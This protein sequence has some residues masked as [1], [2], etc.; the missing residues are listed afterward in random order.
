[1]NSMFYGCSSL[2]SLDLPNIDDSNIINMNSMFYGCSSLIYLNL[3]NF[4]ISDMN[5]TFYGCSSLTFLNLSNVGISDLYSMNSTFYGCSSLMSLDLPNIDI[6]NVKNMNSMFYGC[7]LLTFLDLHNFNTFLVTNMD[8][9]FYGCSSLTSI[10][11]S[12]F[13]TLNVKSMNSM[14]KFCSSLISLDLSNFNTSNVN[15]MDS[16]FEYCSSLAT[17]NLSSFN[18]TNLKTMNSFFSGCSSLIS[19]DLSSF[20]TSNVIYMHSMFYDCS[21]MTYLI[22]SNFDTSNVKEMYSMFS[23]CSILTSLDLSNFK[24]S[25]LE[26]MNYMFYGCSSLTSLD[27]GNFDTSNVNWMNSMFYGCSSLISLDLR[28]FITSSVKWMYSMFYGCS[29]LISLDLTKFDTS[30]V[31]NINSMFYGCSSLIS[32]DLTNFDTS[33]V[34]NMNFMF[35]GCSSLTYINL[36]NFITSKV[37]SMNSMF[38]GCFSLTTLDLSSFD[39]SLVTDMNQM[40]Y[41]CSSL[42]SLNLSNFNTP[43]INNINNM[44]AFCSNLEYINL[45]NFKDIKLMS[46]QNIFYESSECFVLC[47]NDNFN[48][49]IIFSQIGNKCITFDC[50]TDWKLKS[51]IRVNINGLCY[52]ENN[53]DILYKYEYNG[54]YYENCLYGNLFNNSTISRCNCDYEKCS[55]CPKEA[56]KESLCSNCKTNF[57]PIENDTSNIDKYINCY[58]E[59]IGYYLDIDIY[60]KCYNICDHYIQKEYKENNIT[61]KILSISSNA[62]VVYECKSDDNSNSNCNFQNIENNTEILNI[63]K[64]NIVALYSPDDGKSQVIKGENNT[65]FQIT[66]GKNELELLEGGFL[67]NQNISILDL[68]ECENTLKEHYHIN[69]SDSLIILKKENTLGK[70]SEKNVEYEVFEPYNFKPL[71]LSICKGNTINIYVKAELSENTRS[72]YE[73]M[74]SLGYDMLNINDPFYQDICIPYKNENNTD[75]LLSDRINYIYNNKD[76]QCQSNCQFSS[77]LKNSLYLNCTCEAGSDNVDNKKEEDKFSGKKLYESF[78]DVLKYSNFKIIKCYNLVLSKNVVS[79]NFGSIIIMV[80]FSIYLICLITFIIKGIIPLMNQIKIFK[81]K[82]KDIINNFNKNNIIHGNKKEN[83]ENKNIRGKNIKNKKIFH[84]VKKNIYLDK[85]ISKGKIGSSNR[86]NEGKK[87]IKKPKLLKP[88][89]FNFP[90]SKKNFP[91]SKER[92]ALSNRQNNII[93]IRPLT[94]KKAKPQKKLDSFELNNLEYDEAIIWDKRSFI[95][96]YWDILCREHK[97][98]FTFF[99]CNDYNLLNIKYARFIFLVSTDMAMNVFFFSD[100]SMH[101]IFLNYGKYNFIQQIPQI[102]YTTI[103]SQLMEIFLCYLSLTDKHIYAIKNLNQTFRAIKLR[104]IL[105]CIKIKLVSFFIFTFIILGCYWYIVSVFCAVYENTQ[106][107][108]LKDCLSSFGLGLLYPFAIYIIP[109]LLRII[110]IRNPKQKLKCIYKLSDIIPFF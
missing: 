31:M 79:K 101:K 52:D 21:S 13:N 95:R 103:I 39:T 89:D 77:Y 34:I 6:S 109:S 91:S 104:G 96:I 44:F 43:Q 19:L 47:I 55:S 86:K 3:S 100:E 12:G 8:Y 58:K 32:L 83:K 56:L 35:Y 23:G 99:F 65:I 33:Q 49:N 61:R 59:P 26:K 10:N 102:V 18:T 66:S 85:L 22:L 70:P 72:I 24:T 46:Y 28:S 1:M 41:K 16:I 42:I 15:N 84:P 98:L 27:L 80:N 9:M 74:K 92:L 40:F 108:F 54:K 81:P 107:I 75:I 53:T 25:K 38:Y 68:G 62:K 67:N 36:S 2:I 45:Q 4:V 50:S 87:I 73:N 60:R 97:I 106:I 63:I 20:N 105:K 82:R 78:F 30:Q 71:N 11:L 64:E 110:A 88:F 17:L 69:E 76:S 14:F 7:S 48:K 57:Y 5:S 93:N 29:S 94:I 90:N 37:Q 51:K